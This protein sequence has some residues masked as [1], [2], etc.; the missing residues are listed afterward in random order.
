METIPQVLILLL[1]H[2]SK[3]LLQTLRNI[4]KSI[5]TYGD[6]SGSSNWL[7]SGKS[8][9][10]KEGLYTDILK[11]CDKFPH[12]SSSLD[13]TEYVQCGFINI[14]AKGSLSEE[15]SADLPFGSFFRPIFR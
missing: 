10:I 4:H 14:S 2:F 5:N 13:C 6:L 11:N 3:V 1:K 8:V 12:G 7:I 15:F 9:L